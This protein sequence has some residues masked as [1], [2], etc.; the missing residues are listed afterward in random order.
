VNH[1]GAVR[2]Q[3]FAAAKWALGLRVKNSTDAESEQA[4]NDGTMPV[5]PSIPDLPYLYPLPCYYSSMLLFRRMKIAC[6]L[7]VIVLAV[8]TC[9]CTTAPQ[10][11]PAG[12]SNVATPAITNLTGI[13]TG[14][15]VGHT[16]VDG[17]RETGMP[18]FNITEQRG[19]AFAGKKEYT[20]ADGKVRYENLSGIITA[21]GQVSIVDHESGVTS[22]EMTGPDAMELRFLDDGEN[23]KAFLILLNRQKN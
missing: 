21:D 8:L 7:V 14:T 11:T 2:A 5:L 3:D 22:G 1:R 15:A 4:F 17:F 9:G 13:W 6:T 20:L 12:T 23:A 18:R 10:T 16:E 19:S